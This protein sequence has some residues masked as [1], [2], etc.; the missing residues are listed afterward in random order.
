MMPRCPASTRLDECGPAMA[1]R[2]RVAAESTTAAPAD[3]DPG[4]MPL[5]S[6]ALR[7]A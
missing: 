7:G 1:A 5:S 3:G 2:G 6:Q 4:A